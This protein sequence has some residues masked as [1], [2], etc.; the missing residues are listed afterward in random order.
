METFF[1]EFNGTIMRSEIMQIECFVHVIFNQYSFFIIF[2]FN[3]EKRNS[4]Y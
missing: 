1:M 3:K 2:D 4:G